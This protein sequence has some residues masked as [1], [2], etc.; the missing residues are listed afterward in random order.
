MA[1][2][3]C[4]AS[5]CAAC[6][7]RSAPDGPQAPFASIHLAQVGGNCA[8]DEGLA[9][10]GGGTEAVA[11]G[12]GGGAILVSRSGKAAGAALAAG[13]F[14]RVSSFDRGAWAAEFSSPSS[15]VRPSSDLPL[16]WACLAPGAQE[17]YGWGERPRVA[18]HG[19]AL[20]AGPGEWRERARASIRGLQEPVTAAAQLQAATVPIHTAWAHACRRV[21]ACAQIALVC[22]ASQSTP[23]RAAPRGPSHLAPLLHHLRSHASQAWRPRARTASPCRSARRYSP[24]PRTW[25]SSRRSSGHTPTRSTAYTSGGRGERHWAPNTAIS[26]LTSGMCLNQALTLANSLWAPKPVPALNV[27]CRPLSPGAAT[28]SSCWAAVS[29]TARRRWMPSWQRL[30]RLAGRR[31]PKRGLGQRMQ[32]VRQPQGHHPLQHPGLAEPAMIGRALYPLCFGPAQWGSTPC[33]PDVDK[34][35]SRVKRALQKPFI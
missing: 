29:Q 3:R 25:P 20:E 34:S 14:V 27:P 23:N 10:A 8:I 30:Q 1:L 13:D 21:S 16:L 11:A 26:S 33:H 12:P 7:G 15:E 5:I 18:F 2:W 28:A 32:Q 35:C 17:A 22:S 31:R 6:R 9:T 19:H 24:R 4:G